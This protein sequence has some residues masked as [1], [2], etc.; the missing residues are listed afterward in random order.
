[1][2]KS[3]LH[4]AISPLPLLLWDT[5]F[6]I[7]EIKDNR[8]FRNAGDLLVKR[9]PLNR[10]A[11]RLCGCEPA[12]QNH[13]ASDYECFAALCMATPLLV[14]HRAA[15]ATGILLK[16][17]FGLETP[18]PPYQT[19]ELWAVLNE[20]IEDRALRPSDVAEALNVESI[21]YRCDP[22]ISPAPLTFGQVDVY[23]IF[24][25][26]SPLSTL[27]S[28]PSAGQSMTKAV[29][30]LT[31]RLAD[32]LAAGCVSVRFVLPKTFRFARTSRKKEVDDLLCRL[33]EGGGLSIEEKNQLLTSLVISLSR[34]IT[35]RGLILLL[36]TEAEENELIAL[37]DYLALNG[38]VPETLLCTPLPT[39]YRTFFA[40]HTVRTEKGLP[41]LLPVGE[42]FRTLAVS[43]PI[44][45][46]VLPCGTVC[47]TVSLAEGFRQRKALTEALAAFDAEPDTL[48][49][50]AEDV[51]YGNIKNRFSI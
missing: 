36:D 16:E 34:S 19:E 12:I 51:V 20:I 22:L 45:T 24:D 48:A 41:S 32:F 25:L 47:D 21:C 37:Y 43:F 13:E 1:M 11:L 42:D 9:S 46:A 27:A 39:N 6:P 10:E 14:G 35:E 28:L 4:E 5:A 15:T 30:E 23:P 49:S 38:S 44:G 33:A 7:E 50:L 31:D 17:V 40:R 29:K 2:D 8:P 26:A 18:L 3:F